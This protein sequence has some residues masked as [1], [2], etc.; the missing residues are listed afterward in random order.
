MTGMST[1]GSRILLGTGWTGYTVDVTNVSPPGLNATVVV[2]V[3]GSGNLWLYPNTGGSGT[4]TFGAPTQVGSGRKGWQAVDLGSLQAGDAADIFGIDAS[5]NLW[6]YPNANTGGSGWAT[7][8]TP[9][10]VGTGWT[11]YRIN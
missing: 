9:I 4:S 10:Q 2:A 3:D 5:G 11:G 7:W 6:Y 1:F 8:G